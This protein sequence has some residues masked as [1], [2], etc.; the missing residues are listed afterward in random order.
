MHRGHAHGH[1]GH[2]RYVG[3]RYVFPGGRV[4]VYKKPKHIRYYNMHVRP[5][6]LVETYDTIPGYV[7]VGGGWRWGGAEWV[8][9]PGYYSVA[10]VSPP[11]VGVS[12]GFS[13]GV[14]VR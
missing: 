13:A 4:F 8:W 10:T 5:P 2:V 11:S 7:W 6:I 9:S 1:R 3:G 14:T 12:A